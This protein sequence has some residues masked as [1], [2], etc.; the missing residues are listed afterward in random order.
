MLRKRTRTRAGT[1]V[2]V[3]FPMRFSRSAGGVGLSAGAFGRFLAFTE[4]AEV[5]AEKLL[6]AKSAK[7]TTQSTQRKS[8]SPRRPG[9]ALGMQRSET[10]RSLYDFPGREAGLRAS[11][12]AVSYHYQLKHLQSLSPARTQRLLL[13]LREVCHSNFDHEPFHLERNLFVDLAFFFAVLAFGIFA[14]VLFRRFFGR[15]F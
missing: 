13:R 2:S 15:T 7:K 11:L 12:S 9:Y 4:F 10:Q 5:A 1:P 14:D 6:T 3:S 8:P